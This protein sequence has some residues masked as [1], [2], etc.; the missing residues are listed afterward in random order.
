MPI[1][2]IVGVALVTVVVFVLR[3]IIGLATSP[4][5]VLPRVASLFFSYVGVG[6]LVVAVVLLILRDGVGQVLIGVGLVAV[7]VGAFLMA[8]WMIRVARRA[9][10]RAELAAYDQVFRDRAHWDMPGS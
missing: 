4:A 10:I 5:T 3:L 6:S 7:A 2:L 8:G 9:Q 1:L